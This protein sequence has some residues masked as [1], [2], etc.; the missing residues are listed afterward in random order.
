M[1][2][3]LALSDGGNYR[4]ETTE[5]KVNIL[6]RIGFLKVYTTVG[7]SRLSFRM[8]FTRSLLKVI[9]IFINSIFFIHHQ[10]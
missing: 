9:G 8:P 3:D 6:E 7:L 10:Y 4:L 1:K 5:S 2:G